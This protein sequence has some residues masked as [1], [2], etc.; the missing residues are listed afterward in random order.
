[1]KHNSDGALICQDCGNPREVYV[2]EPKKPP[3]RCHACEMKT[4]PAYPRWPS[5]KAEAQRA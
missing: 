4:A 2:R 3:K 1:M 5:A